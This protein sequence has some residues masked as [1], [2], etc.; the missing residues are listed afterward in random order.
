MLTYLHTY[1]LTCSEVLRTEK[2]NEA[3][4]CDNA[5][6]SFDDFKI[7][8]SVGK[9]SYGQVYKATDTSTRQYYTYLLLSVCRWLLGCWADS[10]F[11]PSGVGKMRN[12]FSYEGKGMVL[13]ISR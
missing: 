11:D 4:I 13:A 3:A 12:T 1:A 9:G 6:R 5:K 7:I 10:A 8:S 2:A